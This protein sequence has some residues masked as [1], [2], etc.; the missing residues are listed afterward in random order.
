MT[1]PYAVEAELWGRVAGASTMTHLGT[2]AYTQDEVGKKVQLVD[3]A[4]SITEFVAEMQKILD[5]DD[6]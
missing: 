4:A 1:E 6:E 2:I 3:F 5:G